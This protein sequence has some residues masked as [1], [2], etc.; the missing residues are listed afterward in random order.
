MAGVVVATM[1]CCGVRASRRVFWRL[2]SRV[3]ACRRFF[4]HQCHTAFRAIA[5]LVADHFG[6][7]RAGVF[8]AC[9]QGSGIEIGHLG[10]K[11]TV[12]ENPAQP[13]QGGYQPGLCQ[14]PPGVGGGKGRKR[15]RTKCQD[16]AR[17]RHLGIGNRCG[18]GKAGRQRADDQQYI[19]MA[20]RC[21]QMQTRP[22]KIQPVRPRHIRPRHD[23][24]AQIARH[25][26]R[27]Q[28]PQPIHH[29]CA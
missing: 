27:D 9:L 7:H 25:S 11:C 8:D 13:G 2:M 16:R 19:G 20:R 28:A 10:G 24:G 6:V 3:T 22:G 18:I 26:A 1:L 12:G 5:G 17:A 23:K 14:R 4:R 15:I 29:S 21:R